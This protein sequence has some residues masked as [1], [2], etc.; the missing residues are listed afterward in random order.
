MSQEKRFPKKAKL[1][2]NVR[3]SG[4][5]VGQPLK[6]SGSSANEHVCVH[7]PIDDSIHS[8]FRELIS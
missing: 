5:S 8:F 3:V 6:Y 4:E 1:S 7:E 2:V